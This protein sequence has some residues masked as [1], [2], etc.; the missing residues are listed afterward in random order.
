M[1]RMRFDIEEAEYCHLAKSD[2]SFPQYHFS[3]LADVSRASAYHEAIIKA[4]KKIKE[5]GI[6]DSIYVVV[7]S[8]FMLQRNV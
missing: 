4:V 6:F 8:M 1:H 5:R 3:I 7:F 2:A